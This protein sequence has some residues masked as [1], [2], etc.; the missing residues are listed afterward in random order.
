[1]YNCVNYNYQDRCSGQKVFLEFTACKHEMLPA[2]HCDS[3]GS[4]AL[5]HQRRSQRLPCAS[6]N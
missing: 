3:S 4:R 1:M 6:T 2:A 5:V